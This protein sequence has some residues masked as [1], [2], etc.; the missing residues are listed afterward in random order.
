MSGRLTITSPNE[1]DS[2]TLDLEDQP[3][4]LGRASANSLSYPD[5]S[6]LSRNHAVFEPEG[7]GWIL[8][9]LD[10]RNGTFVNGERV[11]GQRAL[12]AGDEITASGLTIAYDEVDPTGSVIFDTQALTPLSEATQFMRLDAILQTTILL[13]K[14]KPET[15]TRWTGPALALLRAG[16]ELATPRPLNELFEVILK[17]A[18]DAVSAERGVLLTLEQGDLRVKARQGD[19]FRISKSVRDQVMDDRMSLII[20][21]IMVDPNWQ[22]H[23]SIV[24]QGIRSLMAVPLQTDDEAI[25]MLYL[26]SGTSG[27]FTSE[28]LELLTVMANI[29]AIRIEHERLAVVE[30]RKKLLESELEQ[31]GDIQRQCLPEG[32]PDFEGFD[33]AGYGLPCRGVG[34]DYYGYFPLKDGRLCVVIADVAGKG[35]PA[36]LLVMNLQARIQILAQELTDPAQIAARL[37]V[38]M[39]SVCPMGKFVTCFV[40]AVDSESGAV[41]YCNAGHERP[42]L[43]R[44][45]GKVDELAEGGAV[46]GI[47]E[48]L[49]YASGQAV[50][51][52][53]D[54]LVLFT[55]GVSE[56]MDP[57]SNELGVDRLGGL[58]KG[59]NG[60][61]ASAMVERVNGAVQLW[62]SGESAHDDFT[63]VTVVRA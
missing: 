14:D 7:D 48:Q 58:F 43:V 22:A 2:R 38:S 13:V 17:L 41:T 15:S 61:S 51:D 63:M 21:D 57:N 40:C 4:S 27:E 45:S 11:E 33:I 1:D 8:R 47:F 46:I 5:E 23:E 32:P 54:S 9:D 31:A 59:R 25:G 62:Q 20:K 35:M 10:S 6:K 52:S 28:D 26:D 3:V 34:G 36:A 53:G 37:N 30:Q 42:L 39:N 60:A 50:M 19:D 16:R 18:T 44:K 24:S 55:D 49:D 56:A 12:A 29:A